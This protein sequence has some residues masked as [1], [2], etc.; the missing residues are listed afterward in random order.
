M[1][2]MRINRYTEE[3]IEYLREISPNRYNDEITRMFNEKYGTNVTIGAI[4]S[5]KYRHGIKSKLSSGPRA[6]SEEE[7]AYIKEVAVG[8]KNKEIA[9]LVNKRFDT[10]RTAL[11]I[12]AMKTR[13]GIVSFPQKNKPYTEEQIE[14]IR[15]I[16]TGR[17]NL[18]ITKMYNK[19][20]KEERSESGISSIRL[21]YDILT[22]NDGRY[23]KGQISDKRKP[24]GSTRTSKEGYQDI[25]VLEGRGKKNWDRL[26]KV[27][28][29]KKHGPVPEGHIIMFG[30][31]DKSNLD[32]NN[33]ICINRGQM[34]RLNKTDMIQSDAD[35]TRVA[36]NI[37]E[38]ESK[39]SELSKEGD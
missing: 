38:L 1:I 19:K 35:L 36:L 16:A 26:H 34:A 10:D 31:G 22:G 2:A 37:I 6:Y 12:A 20:F 11:S 5:I 7:T 39:V 9:E 14:Y 18:E 29:E 4:N 32:V 21:K 30:D 3:Q 23:K 28:W 33:L 17:T 27:I 24:I 13:S 15:Q 25:K 8:R